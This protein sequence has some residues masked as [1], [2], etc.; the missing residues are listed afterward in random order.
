[1][2][3]LFLLI[4]LPSDDCRDPEVKSDSVGDPA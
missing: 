4:G 2:E 3:I 1:M